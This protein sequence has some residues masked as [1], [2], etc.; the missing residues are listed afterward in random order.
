MEKH[1]HIISFTVPYPVNYGG[2]F[3]LFYKLPALQNEGVKI[4][5][6]CF[7]Y[8]NDP[9]EELNKYCE[10]IHYYQRHE[11]HKAFS[12]CLPYIVASRKNEE[13][14]QNLL[15]DEYPILMEGIHC[16][17][18]LNDERFCNRKKFVRIH[19]VEHQYYH[20]LAQSASSFF[21]KMYYKR[22]SGLLKNYEHS[23]VSKATAFWGVTH[24]DV[25]IYRDEL[26]CTTIDYLPVYLP[27]N[28]QVK[29]L[30]GRGC[31]CL[32][33]GDLSVDINEKAVIWLLENVFDKTQLPFVV[34]GKNP[35][36]RLEK[37]I[38]NR[39][40]TCLVS[41][42]SVKEMQ[43]MISKAHINILPSYSNSG[44]KLKLLNA[45]FN[46]RFCLVND[47][48]IEGS[49]L[50]D[51]C[52]AANNSEEF[53]SRLIELYELP[54]SADEVGK[55]KRVLETMFNNEANAKQQIKWIWGE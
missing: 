54:F 52:V 10:S 25:D 44:I 43:D 2:I 45:L 28:W 39:Q 4:H 32:Y 5:L 41:N 49:G 3:D 12:A 19:N 37:I 50:N 31:Y 23:I 53:Q 22:E 21:K 18:L 20:H 17:Y 1:L 6:H 14:F 47:A 35:S 51:L 36:D 55:R 27:A 46:G 13:L 8:E 15:K 40:H 38:H 34:G 11:G 24:K 29:C 42:P 30:S 48:T 16:S 9:Q 26:G 33:H 7:C